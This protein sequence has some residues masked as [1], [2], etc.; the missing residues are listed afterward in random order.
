MMGTQSWNENSLLQEIIDSSPLQA[1]QLPAYLKQ[2]NKEFWRL[3]HTYIPLWSTFLTGSPISLGQAYVNLCQEMM[4]EKIKFIKTGRY[5]ALDASLV[6]KNL[7]AQADIMKARTLALGLSQFLW[8]NHYR[9]FQFFVDS[10]PDSAVDTY[11]EIGPGHGLHLFETMRLRKARRYTAMDISPA[12]LALCDSLRLQLFPQESI[13]FQCRDVT[14][15]H[16]DEL[17]RHDFITMNEVLEH[18]ND[19]LGLLRSLQQLGHD[20]SL[21]FIST[22]ANSPAVDHVYHYTSVQHIRDHLHNAGYAVQAELA[23]MVG[24]SNGS[25]EA[26]QEV[27]YAALMRRRPS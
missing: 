11:L 24:S 21:Y 12:S 16:L 19:P 3:F 27:N 9:M 17:K 2:Q 25:N 10:L 13:D 5:S 14:E 23:L 1:K 26:A 7:Y 20:S 6:N 4:S 15:T 8:P 22:C 18:V